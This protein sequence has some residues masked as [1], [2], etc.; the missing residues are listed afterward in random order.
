MG[1]DQLF[2]RL[3][4]GEFGIKGAHALAKVILVQIPV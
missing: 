4:H 2:Y 1:F 3:I